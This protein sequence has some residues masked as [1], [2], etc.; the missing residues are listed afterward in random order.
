[1]DNALRA[2]E[3]PPVRRVTPFA[4]A[5]CAAAA[6]ATLAA[7]RPARAQP[8][9]AAAKNVETEGAGAAD[10]FAA[11]EAHER[12]GA[13]A[14][15]ADEYERAARAAPSA[16]FVP[17][18]EARARLL[19]AHGEGD[20]APYAALEA[21]RADRASSDDP[22]ALAAL[23]ARAATFP[24]GPVRSEARVL[25]AEAYAG[26]LHRPADALPLLDLVATDASADPLTARL[27]LDMLVSIQL[28]AAELDAAQAAITRHAALADPSLAARV[29]TLVRRRGLHRVALAVLTATAS[30]LG[31]ALVRARARGELAAAGRA[32]RASYKFIAGVL[33]YVGVV[34][35]LLAAGFERGTSGPFLAFGAAA[36][37]IA[38]GARAWGAIGAAA[39]WARA[40]RAIACAAAV[41]ATAFLVLEQIDAEYLKGFGL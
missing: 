26:R 29:R 16:P 39:P 14:Q 34:G 40:G 41:L 36:L 31:A 5:V 10:L 38:I 33:A 3:R 19:R 21:M 28:D 20:F 4:Y 7:A 11:A 6:V 24:P 32:L 27:A 23:A 13:Y 1:M 8:E 9:G 12:A 2:C 17:R 18:A 25:V 22:R 15:A 30:L 35:G 37:P